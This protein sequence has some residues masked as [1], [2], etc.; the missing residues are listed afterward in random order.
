M[1]ILSTQ[2]LKD[3]MDSGWDTAFTDPIME[4]R[5]GSRPATADEAV[6]GDLLCTITLPASD[7]LT[8]SSG[9]VKAKNGAWVGTVSAGGTPTW[10]RIMDGLD[11]KTYSVTASRLDGDVG[12]SGSGEDMTIGDGTVTAEDTINIDSFPIVWAESYMG[13]LGEAVV[14]HYA[15]TTI[16]SSA[17]VAADGTVA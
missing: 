3:I 16:E 13:A 12:A 4:I 17:S 7:Y 9:G 11:T 15:A 1:I 5:G 14:T 8:A 2:L 6:V 10:F